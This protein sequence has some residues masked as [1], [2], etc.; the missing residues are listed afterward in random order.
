MDKASQISD[1]IDFSIGQPD[2]K[3]PEKIKSSLK[4]AID[5]DITGYSSSSG[6]SSL[7]EKIKKKHGTDDC[8]VTSGV[9][10]AIF[11]SYSALLG[12]GDELIII[13]PY[14]VVY[15]DMCEFL[16]AKPVIVESKEDFSLDLNSIEEAINERTRAIIV[17]HPNNPTGKIYSNQEVKE[18]SKIA[19]KNNLWIIS[20]EVYENFDYED[21]FNSLSCFYDKT[22]I[23]NGFSKCFSM[24]GLRL[25]YAAGPKRVIEDMTKLQ[26]YTFVCA[27]SI[28]QY[29]VN[30]N[31]QLNE[32]PVNVFRERRNFIYE[33]LKN[34]FK[35]IMPEG[36]FYF[37]LGLPEGINGEV[38][39]QECL[40]RGLLVVPGEAFSKRRN[41]IRISYAT[42]MENIRKGV[43]ILIETLKKLNE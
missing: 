25:G 10:A 9:T 40:R 14:F 11:L 30:E 21:K 37:F 22:V 17:N 31:F 39:S 1:V 32:T 24:T 27:P 35:T 5:M 12:E 42:D 29:S 26:Q 13:S 28:S 6:I 23:L 15:P 7:K 33:K 8:I 41:Y 2:F 19:K 38:F 3:V 20:D 34:H 43:E 18:L 4:D 16:G 36:A